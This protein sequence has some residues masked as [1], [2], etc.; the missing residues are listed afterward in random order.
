MLSVQTFILFQGLKTASCVAHHKMWCATHD[1]VLS[2]W[3]SPSSVWG[4][5]GA[6]SG[7]H[8]ISVK[9]SP[10]QLQG[11]AESIRD[12][13]HVYA[14]YMDEHVDIVDT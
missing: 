2:L 3:N 6:V 12:L 8:D 11:V 9:W 5:D 10:L 13:P 4:R 14:A 7:C 1:V